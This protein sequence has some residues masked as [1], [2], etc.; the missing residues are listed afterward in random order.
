[1]DE[2]KKQMIAVCGIDCGSCDIR[3][4]PSDPKAAERLVSWFKDQGWL[5]EGEGI[6]EVIARS[7]YCMGCRGDRSVHW[8]SECWILRCCVDD[9]GLE[10]CYECEDFPCLRLKEWAKGS[11]GYTEALARL[12]RLKE[13]GPVDH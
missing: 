4:A 7:M 3:N 1:M 9:K 12:E 11:A 8:S 13:T 6:D 2:I 5:K 10:Y